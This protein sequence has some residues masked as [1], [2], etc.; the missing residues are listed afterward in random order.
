MN[1]CLKNLLKVCA[2]KVFLPSG[3]LRTGWKPGSSNATRSVV[4]S[5]SG[6]SRGAVGS[7]RPVQSAHGCRGH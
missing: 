2:F 6:R 5:V 3:K 4:G 7:T 1:I